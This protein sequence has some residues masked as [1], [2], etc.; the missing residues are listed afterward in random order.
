MVHN[1]YTELQKLVASK[2]HPNPTHW[3]DSRQ[4]INLINKLGKRSLD[5]LAFEELELLKTFLEEYNSKPLIPS[6]HP[7][8]KITN[9]VNKKL[10][11]L[12]LKTA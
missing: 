1:D 6:N 11:A 8:V 7:F 2:F 3:S 9:I 12:S 5:A 10:E 4:Q